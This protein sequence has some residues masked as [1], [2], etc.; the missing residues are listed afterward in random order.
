MKTKYRTKYLGLVSGLLV[1]VAA[2]MSPADAPAQMYRN[3]QGGMGGGSGTG[4][5]ALSTFETADFSGSGN[6]AFCHS[7]LTDSAGNDVSI[8]AQWRSSMM[9]NS[10]K[11]PLWKAKISSEINRHPALK[12]VIEEKCTRCHMG[13]AR[14][15]AITDGAE[16]SV[17]GNGFLDPVNPLNEAAMDGVSC[18]LC[19][20]IQAADLGR[21]ES[22]TGQYAIDTTTSAPNRA[23]F[24]PYS[25]PVA[26]PMRMHSG[27]TPVSGPQIS[28]SALCG[29]CHTLYTPT[30]DG[31][32][33]VIGEFPEQTTYLEWE[34]ALRGGGAGTCQEC[35][36]PPANGSVVIS[37][38]P[39]W[40]SPREPFGRH[41]FSGGNVFMGG[42]MKNNAS[43][44]GIT[45]DAVHLDA[46]ISR[47]RA[48]L[49]NAASLSIASS[50]SRGVLD[51]TL[52]V[53]NRT[54]HKVPSGIP[55]RRAWLHVTVK[56]AAGKIIFESGKPQADG[57]IAGNDADILRSTYEPHYDLITSPDQ[58]QIYESVM[59][60][61]DNAV[62]YTLLRAARYAKDNR[63]LPAGFDPAAASNDIAVQGGAA[64]DGNFTAAGDRVAYR[65]DASGAQGALTVTAELLFQAVAYPFVEDLRQ[66]VTD[67]VTGF[68]A[69]YDAEPKTPEVVAAVQTTVQ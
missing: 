55:T 42:L 62:T 5:T 59:L 22:F 25:R 51:V 10:A 68:L 26:N 36:V 8:D 30:V 47:T 58:V 64:A 24:G 21:P 3:G 2:A 16:V 4:T 54:G 13:M 43:A 35:H 34:H 37:N 63:L 53:S 1:I 57:S 56:D 65:I 23:I 29:S 49:R 15:Q 17:T 31:G 18:T 69:M 7:S 27:F 61:S 6:C 50:L 28:D 45:A 52:Q 41:E 19:H 9:A 66:D 40:L 33:K 44:L 67:L 60:D 14:Y 20:Q 32:S 11:D 12:S 39:W 46:T 48:M 38:R